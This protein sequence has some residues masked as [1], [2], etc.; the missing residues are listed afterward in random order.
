MTKPAI[1]TCYDVLSNTEKLTKTDDFLG[2]IRTI[3]TESKTVA[4]R[5]RYLSDLND[6]G[7]SQFMCL[8]TIS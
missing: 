8:I 7:E 3:L 2:E 5:I 6:E 4:S 1:L